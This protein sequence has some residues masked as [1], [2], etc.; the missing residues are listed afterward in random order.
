MNLIDLLTQDGHTLKK[1]A[2]THG[3]EYAGPCPFCGGEDRFRVWPDQGNGGRYWCRQCEKHGDSIQYLRDSKGLSYLDA[4]QALNVKPQTSW[5]LLGPR[6]QTKPTW[7]P[8]EA[9]TPRDLW[10]NKAKAFLDQSQHDLWADTGKATRQWLHDRGLNDKTIKQARLGWNLRDVYQTRE[11]WGLPTVISKKTGKPKKLWTPKGL[12]IPYIIDGQIIRVRIRRPDTEDG[13]PYILLPGVDTRPMALGIGHKTVVIVESELDGLLIQQKAG[14]I[15]GVVALGSAQARPDKE[16]HEVLNKAE[17]ILVALDTD[18]AGAKESWQWWTKHYPQTVRWPCPIGKDPGEAYQQ[19]LDI[20]AWVKAGLPEQKAEPK[21]EPRPEKTY[22]LYTVQEAEHD[23]TK[24]HK[25]LKEYTDVG[26][27]YYDIAKYLKWD[28]WVWAFT[29]L[30]DFENEYFN[31]V[32]DIFQNKEL[33]VLCVPEKEIKWCALTQQCENK[34]PISEWF[35]TDPDK[36]RATGN[37]PQALIRAPIDSKWV[38]KVTR[39]INEAQS[40]E[41]DKKIVYRPFPEPWIDK[42][43]ETTLER[44]AIMTVDGVLSDSEALKCLG[45]GA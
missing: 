29:E 9:K 40:K 27:P 25:P 38:V 45:L 22:T 11:S 31:P 7:I 14:V 35:Y 20:L 39:M 41:Q 15:I 19:G 3:G 4:C 16:T 37:I 8:R 30:K 32:Q 17:T 43:D 44:L 23:I 2:G 10:Q 26:E 34:G 21:T 1:A 5:Q 12:V 28:L 18:Q 36:I 6:R 33:W 13:D 24:K 42:Y